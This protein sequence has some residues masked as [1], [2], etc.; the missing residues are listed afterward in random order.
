MVSISWILDQV[1][2]RSKKKLAI[3]SSEIKCYFE[4]L[5]KPLETN[6]SLEDLFNKW[7]HDLLKKFDEKPPRK[8]LKLKNSNPPYQFM[9]TQLIRYW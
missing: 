1:A 7:Q 5:I 2:I 3:I 9:K 8:I 6:K 4:K